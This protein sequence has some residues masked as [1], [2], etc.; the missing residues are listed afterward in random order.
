MP[1]VLNDAQ[2]SSEALAR[3]RWKTDARN[4]CGALACSL[5]AEY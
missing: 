1:S 5:E 4:F 3:E 2:R